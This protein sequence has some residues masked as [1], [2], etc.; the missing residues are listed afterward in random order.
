MR[1]ISADYQFFMHVRG[2]I[3]AS[4]QVQEK[5][6]EVRTVS[7]VGNKETGES[8]QEIELPGYDDVPFTIKIEFGFVHFLC[9]FP[10]SSIHFV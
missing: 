7:I 5:N 4:L 2:H 3:K 10:S 9:N 6:G 1:P 8:T